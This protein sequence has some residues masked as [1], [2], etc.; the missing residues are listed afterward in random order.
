MAANEQ[1]AKVS[2][3]RDENPLPR[4]L[5]EQLYDVISEERFE[6]LSVSQVVGV[7]EFWK[8]NLINGC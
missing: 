2:P 8:W 3:L 5:H 6:S 1:G 4:L 7:L